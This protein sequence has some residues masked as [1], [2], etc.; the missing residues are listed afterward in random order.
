[1][2]LVTWTCCPVLLLFLW[3]LAELARGTSHSLRGQRWMKVATWSL[4]PLGLW[5]AYNLVYR[6]FEPY[7]FNDRTTFPFAFAQWYETDG[8]AA[9]LSRFLHS[10]AFWFWSGI[11]WLLVLAFTALC[12]WMV[13]TPLLTPRRLALM[14]AGLVLLDIALPLAFNCLP[15]GAEDPLENKGSFLHAWFQS[16]HTMLYCMPHIRSKSQYLKHFAELQPCMH[17]SIHGVSHPPGASLILYWLGKPFGA[18][19]DISADRLRYALGTTVF[20]ALAVL[21]MFFLGR[22]LT[23]SSRIGLMAAALWAA[24]PE[25]LAYNTFA[26][27]PT[28]SVLDLLALALMWRAVIPPQ[29]PWPTLAA[30]G[31]ILYLLAMINFNW[32][33]FAGLYGLFLSVHSLLERRTWADWLARA[34]VPAVLLFALLGW[35]CQVYHLDYL[36]IYQY[37]LAYTHHFYPIA[38]AYQWGMALAGSPIDLFLLAGPVTAYLFW[39]MFPI[40]AARSPRDPLVVFILGSL[41]LYLV[42][43]ILVNILKMESSRVWAWVTALP[44]VFVARYLQRSDNPRFFF[45]MALLVALLQ[46]YLMQIFLTPCG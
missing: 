8:W 17:A 33:L 19:Q 5:A 21:A 20:A 26:A 1:M 31:F 13:S 9:C 23:G 44:L 12:L 34:A 32:I 35:T 36:A 30:L 27:D 46:Y 10:P 16:G 22:S 28:Y 41:A 38:G 3:S 37:A 45:L 29:R 39:R 4:R 40:A 7:G 11:V 25:A 14:L 24:K 2:N 42:T 43:A 6:Y 15:D 18:T